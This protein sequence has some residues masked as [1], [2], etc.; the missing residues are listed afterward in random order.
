M[1]KAFMYIL[2]AA[3][4]FCV[5]VPMWW[6]LVGSV[7]SAEEFDDYYKGQKHPA[8][9]TVKPTMVQYK[10]HLTPDMGGNV[11][12]LEKF[13]NSVIITA[14][15]AFL[16]VPL[17]AVFG[18]CLAKCRFRGRN[19]LFFLILMSMLAPLQVTITPSIIIM[20]KVGLYDTFWAIWLPGFVMPFGIFLMRQFLIN[21]PDEV[22]DAA[23]LET[24]SAL[25]VIFRIAVPMVYPAVLALFLL[26]AAEAWNMVEQPLLLLRSY[27][28]QPLSL[29]VND[30]SNHSA[31]ANFAASVMYAAPMVGLFL[32]LRKPLIQSLGSIE[33]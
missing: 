8:W 1:K 12:Y 26:T 9:I 14:V 28:K 21:V 30:V 25:T 13:V 15:I 10:K 29:L 32:I 17:A 16:H 6:T 18:F 20:R 2:I 22:L 11:D 23:K 33:L 5:L 31:N 4:C 7:L 3:L 27:E 24:G 19:L